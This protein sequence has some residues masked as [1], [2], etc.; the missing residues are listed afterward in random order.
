MA[1]ADLDRVRRAAQRLAEARNE[2][3]AAI[4]AARDSGETYQ[5][6]ADVAGL[7]RQRIQQM[8]GKSR[9]H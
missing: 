5:D 1:R 7:S 9:R 4:R 2:M 6:I 3:E 8:I